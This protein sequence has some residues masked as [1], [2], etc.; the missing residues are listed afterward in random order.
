MD[1]IKSQ[2]KQALELRNQEDKLPWAE[3]IGPDSTPIDDVQVII[4]GH[5]YNLS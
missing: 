3:M 1:T 5:R 4:N 2:Y